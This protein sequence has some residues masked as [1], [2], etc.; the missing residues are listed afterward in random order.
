M[1]INKKFKMQSL[2]SPKTKLTNTIL[3]YNFNSI[4]CN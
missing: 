1:P 2:I 4:N 3:K